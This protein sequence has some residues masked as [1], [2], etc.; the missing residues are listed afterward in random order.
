MNNGRFPVLHR[1]FLFMFVLM[2]NFKAFSQPTLNEVLITDFYQGKVKVTPGFQRCVNDNELGNCV[3]VALIKTAL[4][5]FKTIES[6]YKSYTEKN[7]LIDIEFADGVK[8]TI[9][10]QEIEIV[11]QLSGI[12]KII[13]SK[14]YE[15]AMII[16]TSICKRVLLQKNI[17]SGA[18]IQNFTNAVEYIN[19]GFPTKSAHTLLGLRQVFLKARELETTPAAIIWCSAHAAYCSFG[20]Q[21]LLGTV[22]L[23]DKRKMR[24]LVR[25]DRISNAYKLVK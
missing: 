25:K 12:K 2:T 9:D 3:T 17:Y 13:D 4:A 20:K 18:C 1:L 21:D 11:K 24:N 16:Y 6:I 14:Y 5:E 7:G 19:C 23:L 10:R 8:I 22:F 15:S